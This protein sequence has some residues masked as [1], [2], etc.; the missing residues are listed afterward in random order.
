M[1]RDGHREWRR[2]A[3][4]SSL[5]GR[6]LVATPLLGD[7]NF[8]RTVILVLEHTAEGAVGVVLNRPTAVDFIEPL[9]AWYGLAAYPPVLFVGG[10]VAAG[11]AIGLGRSGEGPV[12]T[13]DLSLDPAEQGVEEVRVFSGYAGWSEGQLEDE[14]DAGAWWVVPSEPDDAMCAEPDGLWRAVLKRQPDRLALF[15][16]FPPDVRRN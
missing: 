7:P 16:N 4:E 12:A 1:A 14:L 13:V 10:P 5:R 6:L 8:E 2:L 3:V 9:P 11:S 15:A